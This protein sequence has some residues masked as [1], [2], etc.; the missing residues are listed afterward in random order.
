MNRIQN[1]QRMKNEALNE[2]Q[3]IYNPKCKLETDRYDN[4]DLAVTRDEK[5]GY[6][7]NSLNDNL[8]TDT[9]EFNKSKLE[10]ND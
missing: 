5:I 1:R 10:N 9:K 4:R 6:I 3:K 8:D 7:I 2:I